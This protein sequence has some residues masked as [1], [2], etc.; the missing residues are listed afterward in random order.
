MTNGAVTRSPTRTLSTPVPT[1]ATVPASSWPGTWGSTTSVSWPDQACQSLRHSP[2]AS[3]A[4]T[5]P[6]G[7]ATG[8]GTSR[9][10]GWTPNCSTTTALTAA[11][12]QPG[13]RAV[14]AGLNR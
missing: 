3:T 12:C 1:D 13:R 6:P 11:S 8:S 10:T 9:T 2:V 5:T 7:G 4:T 14:A